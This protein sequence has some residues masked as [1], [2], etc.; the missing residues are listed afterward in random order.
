LRGIRQAGF[1]SSVD[2]I[3]EFQ[4]KKVYKP[5]NII[6][7]LANTPTQSEISMKIWPN[8]NNKKRRARV[9]LGRKKIKGWRR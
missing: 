8:S 5:L 9:C 6:R 7:T 1:C 2:I 3:L 4:R